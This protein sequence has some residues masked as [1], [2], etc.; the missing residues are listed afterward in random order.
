MGFLGH[1]CPSAVIFLLHQKQ[2][3]VQ[4]KNMVSQDC[5][6]LPLPAVTI[7][8]HLL[9]HITGP[10]EFCTHDEA[11]GTLMRMRWQGLANTYCA[12]L[13]SYACPLVPPEFLWI[14]LTKHGSKIKLLKIT[15]WQSKIIK[16][17]VRP[18]W[19]MRNCTIHIHMKPALLQGC[20]L[21]GWSRAGRNL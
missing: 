21:E 6:H 4:R 7:Q 15:N 14:L 13:C 1:S 8:S 5:Q 11:S 19:V 17:N 20:S 12:Y 3:V 2:V 10:L 9:P 16:L 18:F